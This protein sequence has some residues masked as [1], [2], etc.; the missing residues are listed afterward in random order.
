MINTKDCSSNND[1]YFF[2]E[3]AYSFLKDNLPSKIPPKD[4]EKYFVADNPNY[5]CI[6]DV[7]AR[8]IESAQNYQG[9]P[10]TIKFKNNEKEIREILFDYDIPQIVNKWDVEKLNKKFRK[11]FNVKSPDSPKSYWF[12]WSRS[13]MDS[14]AFLSNFKSVEEFDK[15]VKRFCSDL[16]A[17]LALP[18]LIS[19]KIF[20]FGFA[21]ACDVLKELGFYKYCKPDVHLLDIFEKTHICKRDEILVFEMV[22]KISEKCV[23]KDRSITPYKIDKILWLISSGRY[24]HHNIGVPSLKNKFIDFLKSEKE[25]WNV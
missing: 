7:F 20:G 3:C 13:I 25:C 15:F 23:E 22:T 18:L 16:N 14:A 21:L 5:R 10:K 2:Y 24:Y 8:F 9:A 19:R 17:R 4:L 12:K 11:T 1:S 6:E